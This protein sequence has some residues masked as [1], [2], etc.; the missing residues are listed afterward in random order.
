MTSRPRQQ[1]K[2]IAPQMLNPLTFV[3]L[4]KRLKLKAS[5]WNETVKSNCSYHMLCHPLLKLREREKHFQK[6]IY[7]VLI[8]GICFQLRLFFGLK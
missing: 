2:R 1:T 5:D 6:N 7:I 4:I 8:Y 3:Q